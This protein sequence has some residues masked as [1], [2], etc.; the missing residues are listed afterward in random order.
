MS[1]YIVVCYCVDVYVSVWGSCYRVCVCTCVLFFSFK[2][3]VCEHVYTCVM[4]FV[5][6]DWVF[7]CAQLCGEQLRCVCICTAWLCNCCYRVCADTCVMFLC[8][9]VC[10]GCVMGVFVLCVH[11]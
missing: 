9:R 5:Y 6:R 3:C 11:L 7:V 8:E 4:S 10:V 2:S 1:G